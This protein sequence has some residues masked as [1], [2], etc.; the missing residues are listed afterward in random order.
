MDEW[1][2]DDVAARFAEA[3]ETGRRLPPARVQG[4]FNVW[5]A[6]ARDLRETFAMEEPEYRCLPPSPAAIDRMLETMHWM[7][8]L[9]V[10]QRHLVWM[11]ARQY[12]WQ[13]IAKRFGC[14]RTTAWRRW[15]RALQKVTDELHGQVRIP[16]NLN[17]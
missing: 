3:A 4:Y 15:Q 13:D 5:P 8:W 1:D 2:I 9:E 6:F 11:R 14:C 17:T 10:E 12:D 16:E 7:L